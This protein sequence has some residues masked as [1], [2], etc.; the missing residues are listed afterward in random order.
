MFQQKKG[1]HQLYVLQYLGAPAMHCS[2]K[3][4][5]ISSWR[6]H[7]PVPQDLEAEAIHLCSQLLNMWML[8]A[9]KPN[10]LLFQ[11]ALLQTFLPGDPKHE[12]FNRYR[13]LDGIVTISCSA[14]LT[15]RL[16]KGNALKVLFDVLPAWHGL[17]VVWGRLSLC[18]PGCCGT[19]Y[20]DQ[21]D[22]ELTDLPLPCEFWE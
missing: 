22:L 4:L 7:L 19:F 21:T 20:L 3:L 8:R 16:D 9:T 10:Q 17:A 6:V 11:T 15:E 2:E 5:I 12:G 18:S 1:E 13:A 14:G